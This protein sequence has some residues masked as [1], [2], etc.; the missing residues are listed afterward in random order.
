[1][2]FSL[3]RTIGLDLDSVVISIYARNA[4]IEEVVRKV[5]SGAEE[6]LAWQVFR[7]AC[8]QRGVNSRSALVIG[9]SAAEVAVRGLIGTLIPD[10]KWLVQELQTP[11]V[12]RILS[13]FLP[14][15][16][17]RARWADGR[18]ITIP[19][20][21]IERVAKAFRLRN[22]VVHAGKS[23]PTRKQLNMI[24]Q[25]IS[26]LLCICDAYLGEHWSLKHVSLKMKEDWQSKTRPSR[27]HR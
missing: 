1:L 3:A 4:E 27:G 23:P 10:A 19:K 22:D 17:V 9:V 11:P 16:R 2:Q 12:G 24:L 14:T 6:P 15:L 5:E 8:S 20:K 26:D 21:F 13:E 7:E 18:A 25:D